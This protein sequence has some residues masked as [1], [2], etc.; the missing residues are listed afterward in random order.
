MSDKN[1][2]MIVGA[3]S[4][5]ARAF[6]REQRARFPEHIIIT[7]SQQQLARCDEQHIHRVL[8]YSDA[9]IGHA[10][11]ELSAYIGKLQSITLFNGQLHNKAQG[12]A[13]EKRLADLN[14]DYFTWLFKIN[15]LIPLLWL[16]HL[17]SYLDHQNHC[18]I[19]AL[20][21]RVGSISD[22]QLG[23]WYSYRASKAALNMGFK[24][25]AV[26]LKRRAK[27]SKLV[28]FH[29]GTTDTA[30]SQ[31]FL[32]NVPQGKLFTPEF[33]AER[34]SNLIA[35]RRVNGEVDYI[36]WQGKTIPW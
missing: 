26:E 11:K 34:L 36:D 7:F 16:K 10:L 29:P 13:P 21:A 22:N 2:I 6:Y 1:S 32:G 31:P 27:N 24:S 25:A 23:G 17:S 28:L 35:D 12:F 14:E 15:T 33:V 18:V 9:N 3:S 30:L 5:I 20:S 19:T 4:A 8:H